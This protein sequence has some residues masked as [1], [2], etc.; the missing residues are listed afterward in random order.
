[1]R[2]V[3]AILLILAML[4]CA[5]MAADEITIICDGEKV[6]CVNA[7]GEAA[8]PFIEDGT[9]YLPVRAIAGIVGIDISWQDDTK[10]VIIGSAPETA[11]KGEHVNIFINGEAFVAK[12]VNGKVV[13][14]ILLDGT[15]YLPVR[16]ISEAFAKDVEWDN[17][18]KTVILTTPAAGFD[19]YYYIK[20][21]ATGK[22]LAAVDLSHEN[23][24]ALTTLDKEEND[25]FLWRLG[26]LG[27]GYYSIINAASAK[28]V[29]VP[30]AQTESGVELIQYT[31]YNNAN[32]SWAI[33]GD[34]A[35]YTLEAK[36]SGLN[37]DASLPQ[38][39]Q[40][41]KNDTDAQKWIFEFVKPS[42]LR[43]VMESEGYELADERLK[44]AFS[45]YFFG[46]IPLCRA[47]AT[48]AESYLIENNYSSMDPQEQLGAI[49]NMLT[50]TAE[51]QVSYGM[52]DM[53]CAEYEIVNTEYEESYDI[54]RGD[55]KPCWLTYV[56]MQGGAEGEIHEFKVISNQEETPMVQRAIE[57]I[58]VFPYAV[59]QYVKNL[60][61]K[62]GDPA[63]SYNGGG[64][65]IWIRLEWEPSTA[66]VAQTFAHELG[67]VLDSNQL[68]E[69]AIWTWAEAMDACPVSG[70]GS[71]NQAED[72]AEFH[73]LYWTSI[74]TD[75]HSELEKVY[76]NRTKLFRALLYKADKEFFAE[77]AENL[78]FID[79]IRTKIDAYGE[80]SVASQID[81][82]QYYKIVDAVSGKVMTV[83]DSSTDNDVPVLL[84]DYAG[85]DNQHFMVEKSG[86]YVKFIAKHS[87]SGIQMDDSAL[88][89]K[90]LVQYGGQW[91]I[92]DRFAVAEQ[93]GGY[94]FT[95]F[96]YDLG[97]AAEGD[98]VLQNVVP[99]VWKLESVGKV[100]VEEYII[101]LKGTSDCIAGGE[102]LA[103]VT[104]AAK[105]GSDAQS[106]LRKKVTDGEY[107]FINKA[108]G[109]AFDILDVSTLPGAQLI[110]WDLT[111]ADNQ[112][113]IPEE[114]DGGVRLKVK[115]SQ[116]YLTRTDDGVTQEN[117]GSESVQVFVLEKVASE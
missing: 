50:F 99:T 46:R 4:P 88:S 78:S 76:P 40:E 55:M 116:L 54:W 27:G 25:E 5:A 31:F 114:A 73:R 102:K 1:M 110:T 75:Y 69:P 87:E 64:D 12:D 65:S 14:P 90:P 98:A 85:T 58:G 22:Y 47:V 41:D 7:Q 104:L 97:I 18:T 17:D 19:G 59:R 44:R 61:W 111:R 10:S 63:N 53:T 20:N 67:H 13:H 8:P 68:G 60:Y 57:A 113:F 106:W 30:S 56:K 29:D 49:A 80:N 48:R 21:A 91:A 96:R 109:Y 72:L 37:I 83:K 107:V 16:A 103:G 62:Q 32:Q 108:T 35:G 93:D 43:S 79:E 24:A 117:L 70:Y 94:V 81:V 11:Q 95:N 3:L 42:A 100:E 105:D 51:G 84:A 74:G 9:T 2:K 34:E 101:S 66:Q 52:T 89:A 86:G 33:K 23:N 115:N 77:Y 15:T 6:N 45:A 112:I 92:D 71:S 82:T 38:L 39:T 36:H 28:S 26:D